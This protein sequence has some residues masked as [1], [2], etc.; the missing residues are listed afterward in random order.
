[1]LLSFFLCSG[2]HVRMLLCVLVCC[3]MFFTGTL[4]VFER[5]RRICAFVRLHVC[6]GFLRAPPSPS[7]SSVFYHQAAAQWVTL[8]RTNISSCSTYRSGAQSSELKVL[9]K[10]IVTERAPLWRAA[11]FKNSSAPTSPDGRI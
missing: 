7:S 2:L 3:F 9:V 8:W 11:A 6:C 10:D 4:S 1:M 5:V